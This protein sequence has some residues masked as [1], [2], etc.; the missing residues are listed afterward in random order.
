[1]SGKYEITVGEGVRSRDVTVSGI[2]L[3]QLWYNADTGATYPVSDPRSLT[4]DEIT[5]IDDWVTK[6]KLGR[7]ISYSTW[8][9]D[10]EATVTAF[11]LK[12]Q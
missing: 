3:V 5:D 2:G 4:E 7:R 11:L 10:S 12:F 6:G 9:L 1:M 8:R